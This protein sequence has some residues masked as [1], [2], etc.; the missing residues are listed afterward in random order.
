[1]GPWK[2]SE[3]EDEEENSAETSYKVE[4]RQAG[5]CIRKLKSKIIFD[6][7]YYILY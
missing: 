6:Y 7:K 2:R 1:V 3:L 4:K 5:S